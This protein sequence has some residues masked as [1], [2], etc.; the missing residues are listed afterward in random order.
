MLGD[1][2]WIPDFSMIN[3]I[4][5]YLVDN[6]IKCRFDDKV[7]HVDMYYIFLGNVWLIPFDQFESILPDISKSVCDKNDT[8]YDCLGKYLIE[9]L[10]KVDE[11]I[12]NGYKNTYLYMSK[13]TIRDTLSAI[14]EYDDNINVRTVFNP[15]VYLYVDN[16]IAI[17]IIEMFRQHVSS[18][19]HPN[20]MKL[21]S[22]LENQ[23][24]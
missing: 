17:S 23:L 2:K 11:L 4:L 1:A 16:E 13:S 18:T 21:I 22:L 3:K 15:H 14:K 8:Y 9:C 19:S 24:D 6:K 7:N 12:I 10:I 5:D 20:I